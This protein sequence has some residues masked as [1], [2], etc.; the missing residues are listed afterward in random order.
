MAHLP[1]YFSHDL[2][3]QALINRLGK[4]DSYLKKNK[5]AVYR[6][7]NRK[8]LN[9][10]YAGAC[11]ITCFPIYYAVYRQNPETVPIIM[12]FLRK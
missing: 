4:Q 2:F 12:Q 1:Q 3:H 11:T 9:Y 7:K 6:W 5:T 10:I 8:G